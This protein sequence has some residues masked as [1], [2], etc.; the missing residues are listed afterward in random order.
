MDRNDNPPTF[1]DGDYSA[2]VPETL[3]V[4]ATV[5]TL[6][7]E[8]LDSSS[9]EDVLFTIVSGNVGDQFRIVTDEVTLTGIVQVA[10]V[11][12]GVILRGNVSD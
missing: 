10:K 1:I 9:S 3:G 12:R 4:G 11:T 2:T 7:A 8:D 5:L 6:S